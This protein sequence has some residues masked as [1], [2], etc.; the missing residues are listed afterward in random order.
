MKPRGYEI[1]FRDVKADRDFL[2]EMLEHSG[3]RREVPVAL[4]EGR[5]RIGHMG[6]T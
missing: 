1:D 4:E 6:F 3:G 2:A 5:V